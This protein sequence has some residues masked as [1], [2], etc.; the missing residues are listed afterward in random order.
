MGKKMITKKRPVTE[1]S[2]SCGT[3]RN[4]LCLGEDGEGG[5]MRSDPLLFKRVGSI[6]KMRNQRFRELF[7]G[8]E[9]KP[10][11]TRPG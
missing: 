7:H 9:G 1:D 8:R 5:G 11:L 10:F 2:L 4:A 3:G 6:E